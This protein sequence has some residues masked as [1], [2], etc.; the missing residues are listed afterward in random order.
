MRKENKVAQGSLIDRGDGQRIDWADAAKGLSILLVVFHHACQTSAYLGQD[1]PIY[2]GM[3]ALFKPIRMPLFFSI[4]GMFAA[5]AVARNWVQL[6]SGRVFTLLWLYSLWTVIYWLFFRYFDPTNGL[7]PLGL[8]KWQII[9][10]WIIP[11]SGQW[12][13]WLMAIYLVL[14]KILSRFRSVKKLTMIFIL[15][16]LSANVIDHFPHYSWRNG[17]F[18]A[19]FF[20]GGSWYGQHIMAWIPRHASLLL[21]LGGCSFAVLW[22]V[23]QRYPVLQTSLSFTGLAAVLGSAVIA[24]RNPALRSLLVFFGQRT[25]A[26]YMGHGL[27]IASLSL[28]LSALPLPDQAFLWVTPF[29]LLFSLF[30]SLAMQERSGSFGRAWLYSADGVRRL[31]PTRTRA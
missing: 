29:L 8:S 19:P 31:L 15:C 20:I 6:L 4:A 27:A 2:S 13:L 5:S 22:G 16:T 9:A 23:T 14:A 18:Y 17:L 3:N 1:W 26:I 7:K 12:F 28:L 24:S 10:M 21:L 25:L 11:P 30:A